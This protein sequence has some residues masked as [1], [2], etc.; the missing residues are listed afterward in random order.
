MHDWYGRYV[1]LLEDKL[2]KLFV[3]L[4]GTFWEPAVRRRICEGLVDPINRSGTS[5]LFESSDDKR[6]AL[7]QTVDYIMANFR[8]RVNSRYSAVYFARR[9][10]SEFS[11]LELVTNEYEFKVR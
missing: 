6:M 10:T 2:Q 8:F 9:I 7:S 5:S 4:V 1:V 11:L 3:D